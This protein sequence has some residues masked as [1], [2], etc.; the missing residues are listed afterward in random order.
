MEDRDP[1]DLTLRYLTH[2]N[3]CVKTEWD[4]SSS[5]VSFILEG[6]Q[7]HS[8]G[9]VRQPQL[10][11]ESWLTDSWCLKPSQ[12][13]WSYQDETPTIK[14]HLSL[15]CYWYRWAELI[16]AFVKR[17]CT[18]R[19]SYAFSTDENSWDKQNILRLSTFVKI[20]SLRVCTFCKRARTLGVNNTF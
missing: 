3:T 11:K 12:L 13:W 6:I 15:T 16:H 18:S 1:A 14:S 8:K 9:R 2:N 5:A 10:Q 7:S 19:S 4:A 20:Y 17:Q